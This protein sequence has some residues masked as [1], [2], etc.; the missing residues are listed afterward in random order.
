[1]DD[2]VVN[3]LL[4]AVSLT[5]VWFVVVLGSGLS[6]FFACPLRRA[7]LF[8]TGAW[9]VAILTNLWLLRMAAEAL[10]LQV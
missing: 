9:A 1:M 6:V 2:F 5:A 10:H 7:L 4:E 3:A 8:A